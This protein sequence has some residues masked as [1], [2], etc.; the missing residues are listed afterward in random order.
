LQNKSAFKA[1]LPPIKKLIFKK[2]FRNRVIIVYLMLVSSII[3]T[4]CCYFSYVMY[5]NQHRQINSNIHILTKQC[6]QMLNESLEVIESTTI[7]FSYNDVIKLWL[8]NNYNLDGR[9]EDAVYF[10]TTLEGSIRNTLYY[11]N[12]TIMKLIDTV[13]VFVNED[14]MCSVYSR[15]NAVEMIIKNDSGLC[16]YA[17]ENSGEFVMPVYWNGGVY[18]VRKLQKPGNRQETV[19]FLVRLQNEILSEK[20]Q[21]L[22]DMEGTNIYICDRKGAIVSSNQTGLSGKNIYTAA[23]QDGKN[24]KCLDSTKFMISRGD[25]GMMGMSFWVTVPKASLSRTI[26]GSMR[27]YLITM[28]AI[29]GVFLVVTFLVSLKLTRFLKDLNHCLH[30]VKNKNYDIIMPGYQHDEFNNLSIAFN[31][32]TGEIKHL[33]QKVYHEQL[34][35]KETQIKY[36]QSQINPHFLFNVLLTISTKARLN[37]EIT[38]YKMV[39]ALSELLRAGINANGKMPRI[40]VGDEL[41]YINLYLYLQKIRFEGKL[42]YVLDIKDEKIYD[43]YIPRLSVE[44]IVEN[45]VVHGLEPIVEDGLLSISAYILDGNLIFKV[46]DNGVGFDVEK[47][48]AQQNPDSEGD[49]TLHSHIGLVNTN[50]RIKLIY[51]NEYGVFIESGYKKGTA[52]TIK[53]PVDDGHNLF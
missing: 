22:F 13:S 49:D 48:F 24:V 32:M 26:I 9:N 29:S 23:V 17:L 14:Y 40:K 18:Y 34:L 51:G 52:V 16:K 53:F 45:A 37:N 4:S 7:G 41:K 25:L 1:S 20:Y 50:K 3:I 39:D 30:E 46:I 10:K 21:R 5:N 47:V 43:L 15:S 12:A 31:T 2:S 27:L 44:P 33:I 11:S 36:L 38:T 8:M 28:I 19:T 42:S 6:I 35:Q